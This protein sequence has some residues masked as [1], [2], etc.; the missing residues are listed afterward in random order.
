MVFHPAWGYFAE[1]YGLKQ[2]PIE[3]QGKEPRPFALRHLIE[4]AKDLGIKVIFAQS[5]F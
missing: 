2:I 4:Q 3:I 5:Q 1:S